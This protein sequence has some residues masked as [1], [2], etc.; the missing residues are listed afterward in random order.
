MST[1]GIQPV[2]RDTFTQCTEQ[3]QDGYVLNFAA[4]AGCLVEP[5]VRDVLGLDVMFVKARGPR[6]EVRAHWW[7]G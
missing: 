5:V 1:Q 4:T 2:Y 6:Q 7:C 3:L